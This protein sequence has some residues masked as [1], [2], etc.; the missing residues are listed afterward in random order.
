MQVQKQ[1]LIVGHV[2]VA[3][4]SVDA[5]AI[6][7]DAGPLHPTLLVPLTISMATTPEESMI[8]IPWL[9]TTLGADR[10]LTAQNVITAPA[11]V[12]MTEGMPARSLPLGGNHVHTAVLAFPVTAAE[13]ASIEGRRHRDGAETIQLYLH[14]NAI[15]AGLQTYNSFG[16]GQP[17]A[18]SP[19][20]LNHGLFSALM[21]FWNTHI[22]PIGIAIE[23]SVWVNSVLP[24]LGYDRQ[25]LVELS[26]PPTLPDRSTAAPQWDKARLAFDQGRYDD[27]IAHCRSLLEMWRQ[28]LGATKDQPVASVI[29]ARLKWSNDDQRQA[30]IDSLWKAMTDI[31]NIT[32]HPEGQPNTQE[33]DGSLARLVLMITALLSEYVSD[34]ARP[35]G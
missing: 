35:K 21:P 23:P 22:E 10:M 26:F 19:W 24:G 28:Q 17:A 33:Y 12:V 13:I 15:V 25:R 27:C 7:G 29:A 34:V 20:S 16:P 32:H 14:I 3:E 2:S 11:D 31:V 9:R 30:F 4:L 18:E 1:A 5:G 6:R 8:A